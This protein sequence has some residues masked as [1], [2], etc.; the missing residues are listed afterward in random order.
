MQSNLTFSHFYLF[1]AIMNHF[2]CELYVPRIYNLQ[3]KESSQ[4]EILLDDPLNI[5]V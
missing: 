1:L 2:Q 5:I 3:D 4:W